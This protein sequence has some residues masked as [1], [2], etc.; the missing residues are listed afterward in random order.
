MIKSCLIL[1]GQARHINECG[2]SIKT[3]LIEP[4]NIEDVY[5]HTWTP[6]TSS[7]FPHYKSLP[8]D[9]IAHLVDIYN[10]KEMIIERSFPFRKL[11]WGGKD[12]H[13]PLD[14]EQEI[15]AA[16]A[17]QAM[18]YSR[19]RAG[20]LI[21][22]F[23]DYDQYI[24]CRTDLMFDKDYH[25]YDINPYD[26][27]AKAGNKH[28]IHDWIFICGKQAFKWM[29]NAYMY[30]DQIYSVR[31]DRTAETYHEDLCEYFKLNLIRR[32]IG[33]QVYQQF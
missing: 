23:A 31:M 26:I 17:L 5:C 25:C 18:F 9:N 2:H 22:E 21:S 16:N 11:S 13:M 7:K 24:F 28:P 33:C 4:N 3:L 32:Y 27:I 12:I 10:P 30:M 15:Y 1:Y 8:K 14:S 20:M 29:R 6:Q 19:Y